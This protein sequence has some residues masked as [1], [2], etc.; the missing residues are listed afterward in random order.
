MTNLP[1][2]VAVG[3]SAGGLEAL[4]SMLGSATGETG[5]TFVI[6][7]HLSPDYKSMMTELLAR[8]TQLKVQ[9][10]QDGQQVQAETV[11]VMEPQ[12]QIKLDGATLRVKTVPRDERLSQPINDFFNSAAE[13]PGEKVAVVLSGTGSDGTHGIAAVKSADGTIVVQEPSSAAFDGMPQSAIRTGLVDLVVP[14]NEIITE[15]LSLRNSGPEVYFG[16]ADDRGRVVLQRIMTA[17]EGLSGVDFTFYKPSTILRRIKRRMQHLELTDPRAY[18]DKLRET[19]ME[20]SA[21]YH[22]L[23]IGVTRFFRDPGAISALSDLVMPRVLAR[24]GT[25][26]IRA[27]VAGC[28]TG[29][30]AYTVAILIA[31]GLANAGLDRD[32]RVF[33]TDIDSKAL[34]YAKAGEFT[35]ESIERLPL[36][37]RE[38]YFVARGETFLVR[39]E[40]REHLL[41]S[42]HNLIEAPPFSR[43]DLISCRNLL[44]YLKPSIQQRIIQTFSSALIDDGVLWLG[45]S[46][47]IGGA[48]D[49]FNTLNSRWRL[50]QARPGRRRKMIPM[51][52]VTRL[53][54]TRSP[55]SVEA[56]RQKRIMRT[57]EGALLGYAPPTLL[58]DTEFQLI[59]RYGNLD[60]LLS[61]PSGAMT[62]DVREMLPREL[63]AII[64]TAFS[65]ARDAHDDLHYRG[66]R[67]ESGLVF[68]MRVRLLTDR[69]G[70]DELLALIFEGL[71]TEEPAST[72]IVSVQVSGEIE[73][74]L[75]NARRDL[76]DTRVNLQATIEELETSNEELQSTNEELIAANEELQSTNEELQSVNEE[77]HTVNAEHQDKVEELVRLTEKLDDVLGAIEVGVV[78]LDEQLAVQHFNL[79]ATRYFNLIDQDLGRPLAHITHQM[80]FSDLLDRCGDALRS[81]TQTMRQTTGAGR[82]VLLNILP[83]RR[84]HE[85]AVGVV[86]TITDVTELIS[87][88]RHAGEF[89]HAFD[90]TGL[91]AVLIDGDGCVQA[92]NSNFADRTERDPAHLAGQSFEAFIADDDRARFA[93]ALESVRA[94][95]PWSSILQ[96][97]LPDGRSSWMVIDLF[98]SPAGETRTPTVLCIARP[99]TE[100]FPF[101]PNRIVEEGRR[102]VWV[103]DLATGHT[104]ASR[105]LAGV[106]GAS[107]ILGLTEYASA[108]QVQRLQGLLRQT[109]ETLLPQSM[110][111]TVT[112]DGAAREVHVEAH[113]VRLHDGEVMLAGIATAVQYDE[114][115]H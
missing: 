2:L 36:A 59:Y 17:L 69:R 72:E 45:S 50:Y 1:T 4:S 48:K 96:G 64:Y 51:A 21:L 112:L 81:G 30:E 47:T 78:V 114:Q 28:S 93:R 103:H 110:I 57:L 43:L 84:T 80:A 65:R 73:T 49:Q 99:F 101:N 25:G 16:L 83:R 8:R 22:D 3:A 24:A 31:E 14:A 41:F 105:G 63:S 94:G 71:K 19:P 60:E 35:G 29:E 86:L 12:A 13:Y 5:M 15:L 85:A 82:T 109:R 104:T 40:I 89:Q 100:L 88:R 52:G 20:V 56:M 37:V 98:V 66:L 62:L 95:R 115:A 55:S 9:P 76:Q 106:W 54:P 26:P 111:L 113:A 32:F 18:V 91:S 87:A 92:F 79:A 97:M 70:E 102:A 10:A 58:I 53:A 90:L 11:Y 77:L 108:E 61:V 7:Q 34:E 46:E 27:W 38:K 67:L 39:K 23:L 68:D 74:E 75:L 33:A 6:I 107:T 42:R 44:I